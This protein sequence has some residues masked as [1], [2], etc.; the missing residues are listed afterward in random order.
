[1]LQ[2]DPWGIYGR[3][4]SLK[5]SFLIFKM[6]K[7]GDFPGGPVV[8]ISPPSVG[9]CGFGPWAGSSKGASAKA[10]Q[11][12]NLPA[13]QEVQ[14]TWVRSLGQDQPPEEEMQPT[15]VFLPGKFHG[16]RSLV[17]C[18]PKGLQESDTTERLNNSKVTAHDC[19]LASSL[20]GL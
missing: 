6:K 3:I 1:M 16:Q 14:E 11:V 5:L 8:R 17:G 15:P 20:S 18:S 4:T 10:Q 19:S 13:M 7:V 9:G 2:L 12:K